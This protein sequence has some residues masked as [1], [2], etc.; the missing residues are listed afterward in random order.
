MEFIF[1]I[2]LLWPRVATVQPSEVIRH[3]LDT[4]DS[5]YTVAAYYLAT[6]AGDGVDSLVWTCIEQWKV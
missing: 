1:T 5:C 3:V 4:L 2:W 6:V